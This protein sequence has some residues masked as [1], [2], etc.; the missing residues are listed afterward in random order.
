MLLNV[1]GGNLMSKLT[2]LL[3]FV[4]ILAVAA[5]STNASAVTVIDFRT[6]LAGANGT[7]TLNGTNVVGAD[8]P[9]GAVTIDGAPQ[10]DGV[11]EADAVLNFNTAANTITIFGTVD[12]L[13][14]LPTT[15][16][17]GSFDSFSYTDD[18]DG[19]GT[20]IFFGQG[21]DTKACALICE[22]GLADGTPFY[23]SGV[24][25]ESVNETVI[26]TDFVNTV[27]PVPA[28]VWL[29]GSG[30]IGLIGIARRKKS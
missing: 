18:V 4:G 7:L 24:T 30:L 27:V 29:F 5:F 16:L 10:G 6:G 14:A 12:T 1:M 2:R 15:L 25:I 17:S 3:T 22:L 28:A 23:F 13:V 26:S 19:L 8:I 20:D 9:I 11:Y 21:P